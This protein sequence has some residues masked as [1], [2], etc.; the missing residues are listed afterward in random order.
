MDHASIAK[1]A[2]A[3]IAFLG[4][5]A[6]AEARKKAAEALDRGDLGDFQAWHA[7]LWAVRGRLNRPSPGLQAKL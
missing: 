1:V 3:M 2:E 4:S 7:I 6:V 5:S